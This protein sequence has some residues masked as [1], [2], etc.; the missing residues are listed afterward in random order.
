VPPFRTLGVTGPGAGIACDTSPDRPY[1]PLNTARTPPVALR[2]PGCI[3]EDMSPRGRLFIAILSTAF[4]GYVAV[5]SLLNRVLGDTSY[6]Q[7]AIFNDVTR[8]VLEAYV[9]PVNLDRAMGGARL[10]LTEAL[11][12]DTA[13]L[14]AEEWKAYQQPGKDGDAEVGLTL[15]RRLGFLMVV[16]ARTAS[17]A[18]KAGLRPGDV[19]K[20]IDGRHTRPLPGPVGQRLLRGA[21]G[22]VVK[23]TVLRA[24]EPDPLEI[25]LVRER[26]TAVPAKGR[27]LE[28]NA[29]TGYLKVA[30]L[31][32]KTADDVRS[33]LEALRRAGA[34]EL[35][36]DLRGVAEGNPAEA[37]KVAEL[38][39]KG[40]TVAKLKGVHVPEQVL[41]ANASHSMWDLPMT[42][43]IDHGTAGAGEIVASALLDANRSS[44]VGKRTFGRAP[45]LKSIPLEEGGI[46]MTVAKYYNSKDEP[47]HGKGV[48][49]TVPVKTG[50]NDEDADDDDA[51]ST[52]D[53]ILEKAIEVLHGAPEV[54]KAA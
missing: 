47:I 17:P 6:T 49:P 40:G 19:L 18:E 24:G 39:M 44:L 4:V 48:E 33:E 45:S 21:P 16:S 15:S 2:E 34:R 29:G 11:D 36:L 5:G 37:V 20:A 23:I 26:P 54:K 1:T 32:D 41:S 8:I 53:L 10:G 7:L 35:V 31:R 14:D 3:I 50:T 13:Y 12:G 30:E 43:L 28:G 46:V 22:S 38:F 51:A 52:R 27:I 42:T 25:S 9:E